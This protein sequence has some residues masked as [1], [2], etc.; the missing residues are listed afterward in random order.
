MKNDFGFMDAS[1]ILIVM[2]FIIGTII[3]EITQFFVTQVVYPDVTRS[4][5]EAV[6]VSGSWKETQ[7]NIIDM[8]RIAIDLV[9]GAAGAISMIALLGGNK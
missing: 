2:G 6:C 5:S 7:D 3:G 4:V 9:F 1:I 8:G